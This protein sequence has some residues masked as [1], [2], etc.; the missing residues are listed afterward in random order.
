[1]IPALLT[2]LFL[3][4]ACGGG[5]G[6]PSTSEDAVIQSD[7]ANPFEPV[8]PTTDEPASEPTA[9]PAT[10]VAPEPAPESEPDPV[11]VSDP[12]PV[13]M[14]VPSA[15]SPQV[16]AGDPNCTAALELVISTV[17]GPDSQTV[18]FPNETPTGLSRFALFYPDD[19]TTIILEQRPT[20]N[21]NGSHLSSAR[22]ALIAI[23]RSLYMILSVTSKPHYVRMKPL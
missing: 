15:F 22:T 4:T 3:L 8:P 10:P 14:T 19:S 17:G 6:D 20:S 9:P 1:M 18:Q 12:G 2:A 16:V 13:S 21:C 23:S 11:V 5:S 7:D